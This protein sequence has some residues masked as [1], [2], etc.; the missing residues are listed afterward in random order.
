MLVELR[1]TNV[2]LTGWRIS[3]MNTLKD[4]INDVI[5][6]HFGD[7]E[8]AVDPEVLVDE[9]HEKI[10]DCLIKYIE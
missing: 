10:K 5:M 3:N 4:E 2:S 6:L 8:H 7:T 1:K 9:V